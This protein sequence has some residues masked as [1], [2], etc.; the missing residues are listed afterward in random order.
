MGLSLLLLGTLVKKTAIVVTT[1]F[2]PKFL[3]GYLANLR[4]Y[5][6]ESSTAI[7]IVIDRKTPESVSAA[8]GAARAEGF[9]VHCPSLDEQVQS[10]RT[11]GAP[12]EFIPWNTDNRRNV[13][14]LMAIQ[15][16]CE[17]L[18]SIDDDNFCRDN[19]DFVG[20]H[21][22][23][24]TDCSDPIVESSDGWF[25]ICSLM[26]SD[27]PGEVF[28][29]GFPYAAQRTTRTVTRS[30]PHPRTIAINAG[31]WSHDPDID[32]IYRLCQRPQMTTFKNES[33]VLGS[34]VWS[35]VNTQN[36]ALMRELAL[37]Y[38]YVRMGFPLQ[39]LKIDRFGD[40][41]SGYLCQKV[42][43]HLG[44]GV[45][46]G[47]P[48]VDHHRTVHNLFKDLYHELAGIV[49]IEDLLPWLREAKL[50]GTTPLDA[51]S[52]LA[53]RMRDAS[54]AFRGFVW[55]EG[56]REFLRETSDCMETWV[57]L[58]RQFA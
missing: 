54:N 36:T 22:V 17:T 2:E 55:D 28:P 1:I 33:V 5:G 12:T 40:I 10:L 18:I 8:A 31:L 27:V 13:G 29:R 57:K 32:A 34:D 49:L 38:Y 50:Q 23:V 43:R 24:G 25:N 21:S 19:E 41:L 39:G 4:Q 37:T 44:W 30:A 9:Q 51:Y 16:G 47:S 35:P 56:G 42:A 14:F 7:Y 53:S 6:R 11:I 20:G 58:V 52:S 26:N 45:R 46:L 3:A 48:V 15:D